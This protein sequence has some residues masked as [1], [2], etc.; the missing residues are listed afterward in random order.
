MSSLTVSMT[1]SL[2]DS[3]I[4]RTASRWRGEGFKP[5]WLDAQILTDCGNAILVQS[6]KFVRKWREH[7]RRRL[8]AQELMMLDGHTC[9]D[10]GLD[11]MQT[12][13]AMS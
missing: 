11:K 2:E 4:T 7:Q 12:L 9:K 13:Y 8:A 10:I 5:R 1:K 6:F 3:E